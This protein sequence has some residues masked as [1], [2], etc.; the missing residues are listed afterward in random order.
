MLTRLLPLVAL[1]A[2]AAC[3]AQITPQASTGAS[4]TV[5]V[6]VGSPSIADVTHRDLQV[7]IQIAQVQTPPDTQGVACFSYLDSRLTVLQG[8]VSGVIPPA[9]VISAFEAAHV[10]VN[11]VQSGISPANRAALE[12]ACGPYLMNTLGG[13][14]A[15]LRQFGATAIRL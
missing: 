4:S 15:L 10:G 1:L 12:T 9:G 11:R 5:S 14:N 6:S 7:A 13:I 2:L 3:S 8:Q